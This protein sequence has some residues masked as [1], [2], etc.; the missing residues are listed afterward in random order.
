MPLHIF[1]ENMIIIEFFHLFW[2]CPS[3]HLCW[4]RR[5]EDVFQSSSLENVFKTSS[6]CK[7]SYKN[8]FKTSSRRLAMLFSRRLAKTSL[9]QLLDVFKTFSRL[10][11][12]K[13]FF[14]TRPKDVF[15][16]YSTRFWDVLQ[17]RLSTEGFA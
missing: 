7:T 6:R 9:R 15:E 1:S 10:N 13:L 5:L 17:R 14:L 16:T 3:K 12:V 2:F 8:V 4:W 11:Q